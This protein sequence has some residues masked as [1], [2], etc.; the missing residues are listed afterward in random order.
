M[1]RTIETTGSVGCNIAARLC[2][3]D[4]V[5]AERQLLIQTCTEDWV[6]W[7]A[8]TNHMAEHD[9]LLGRNMQLTAAVQFELAV[10]ALFPE[11]GTVPEGV[12]L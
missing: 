5:L 6:M 2:D 3:G 7:Q 8:A 1:N 4:Q 10:R 11:F 9:R 12:K